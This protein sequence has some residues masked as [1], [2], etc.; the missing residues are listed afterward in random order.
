ML[1]R[2][3]PDLFRPAKKKARG[4]LR[5]GPCRASPG[6]DRDLALEGKATP[7]ADNAGEAPPLGDGRQVVR[8]DGGQAMK[9]SRIAGYC[10]DGTPVYEKAPAE[11]SRASSEVRPEPRECPTCEG[12]RTVPR[13]YYEPE[14]GLPEAKKLVVCRRCSGTGEIREGGTWR[15]S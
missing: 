3:V 13:G 15:N 10:A 12:S 8:D 9:G 1:K 11:A 7:H 2:L 14:V 6:A 4:G 5:A